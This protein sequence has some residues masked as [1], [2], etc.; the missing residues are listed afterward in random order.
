MSTGQVT[1]SIDTAP[2]GMLDMQAGGSA[3][4]AFSSLQNEFISHAINRNSVTGGFLAGMDDTVAA[5]LH[6]IDDGEAKVVG[7]DKTIPVISASQ[8]AENVSSTALFTK[9]GSKQFLNFPNIY[10]NQSANAGAIYTPNAIAAAD[11][12]LDP[13]KATAVA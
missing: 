6:E 5:G 3:N 10:N 9:E 1:N 8:T 2:T 4:A 11:R 12:L 13:K 7:G